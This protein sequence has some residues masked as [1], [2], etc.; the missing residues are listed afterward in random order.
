MSAKGLLKASVVLFSF[1]VHI[2]S[3]FSGYSASTENQTVV[4]INLANP[5]QTDPRAWATQPK[6]KCCEDLNRCFRLDGVFEHFGLLPHCPNAINTKMRLNTRKTGLEIANSE[7]LDWRN[8]QTLK[9]SSFDPSKPIMIAAHGFLAHIDKEWLIEMMQVSI[10]MDDLNFVRV[11][12]SGASQNPIY[13]QAAADTQTV[14]AEVSELLKQMV[15]MGADLDKVWVIGHSLGAHLSGFVGHYMPGIGRITGLDPAEPYFQGHHVDARLDASDGKFVDVIHTDG[16]SI[17]YGGFGASDP[18]GHVDYYPNG[19]SKQPGCD[20]SITDIVDITSGKKYVV[21]NH[22]RAIKL[23]IETLRQ[24]AEG[25][26]CHFKAHRCDSYDAFL[27]VEC[28]QCGDGCSVMGPRSHSTRP[29]IAETEV[30][31][32]FSTLDEYPFCAHEMYDFTANLPSDFEENK[33]AIFVKF[34]TASGE[35]IE[36]KVT[37][38]DDDALQPQNSIHHLV[39]KREDINFSQV[40]DVQVRYKH[41]RSIWDPSTWGDGKIKFHSLIMTHWHDDDD[42]ATNYSNTK[43]IEFCL[44]GE[45]DFELVGRNNDEW[46]TLTKCH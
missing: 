39:V 9:D 37:S 10:E 38:K 40:S 1:L 4:T 16:A 35:T 5:Q 41:Y 2:A 45:K 19:G 20:M 14:A 15:A 34:T 17:F 11:G 29:N 42:D 13:P 18:M 27:K 26:S 31:M 36:E 33:G 25:H 24:R 23:F 44:D 32:Y 46:V 6:E 8:P 7:V 22:E 43:S 21:C 28:Q 3:A 30:K 12:W